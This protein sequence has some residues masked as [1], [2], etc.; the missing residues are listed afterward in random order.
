MLSEEPSTMVER[1]ARSHSLIQ[2]L[3]IT[4]NE[5]LTLFTQLAEL[6]PFQPDEG[7]CEI[8]QEFCETLVDYTLQ[9]HLNLYR[10]I[11]EKLE[12]R[13]KVLQLA[14]Q[15]YPR[16]LATTEMISAF[17][18]TYE[19]INDKLDASH[20]EQNLSRLGEALAT[21]IEL[22]DQLIEVLTN[23]MPSAENVKSLN[24]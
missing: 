4:R 2:E 9:A 20:L 8:L 22:E 16:I 11:E 15:I 17:N 10:Y 3:V 24:S 7:T 13:K 19:E 14:E 18:D 5:M 6:K 12:K 23:R 21:R 1:R